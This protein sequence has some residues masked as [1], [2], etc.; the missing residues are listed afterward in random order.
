MKNNLH[1]IASSY[2]NRLT[3]SECSQPFMPKCDVYK[4]MG[5]IYLMTFRLNGIAVINLKVDPMH[6][7]MLRDTYRFIRTG[8]HMNKRHWISIYEDDE[9]D[10]ELI[11][12]LIRD[13]YQLVIFQ[14]PKKHKQHLAL[15]QSLPES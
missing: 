15:L 2:V 8:Y 4:V 9:I 7:E 13:S 11:E 3:A 12:D 1:H 14:L 5:K 6:G 10:I